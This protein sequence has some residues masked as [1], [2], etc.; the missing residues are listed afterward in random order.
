VIGWLKRRIYFNKTLGT[1]M[2]MT[3][4]LGDDG[5][6]LAKRPGVRKAIQDNFADR[7]PEAVA[8]THVAA[9]LLAGE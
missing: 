5:K 6:L 8:A 1:V 9:F 3:L 2:A 4:V 7:I